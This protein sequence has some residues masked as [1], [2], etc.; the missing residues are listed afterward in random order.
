[1]K[2]AVFPGSFDPITTGHLDLI[3]RALPLFD[4]LIIAVGENSQKKYLFPL[5]KRLNWLNEVFKDNDKIEV[6]HFEG[7][8]VNYCK[9]VKANY[10]LRGLRNSSDFDYEKTISQLNSII[11]DGL[12]T[13]FLISRPNYSHISSTIVREIIKG[14]GDVSSFV[15]ETIA[16][17]LEKLKNL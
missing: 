17:D 16:K 13:L 8:T 1:M 6:G 3:Y 15:P 10:L 11:G 4:K 2:I 9:A 14:N 12:E 7:L 5:E